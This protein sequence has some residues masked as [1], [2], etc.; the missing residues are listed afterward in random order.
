MKT[1]LNIDHC[2]CHYLLTEDSLFFKIKSNKTRDKLPLNGSLCSSIV[3]LTEWY[4]PW[5]LVTSGLRGQ[6]RGRVDSG[7]Q[8]ERAVCTFVCHRKRR[9]TG[10]NKVHVCACLLSFCPWGI[11]P[12]AQRQ[13]TTM[14]SHYLENIIKV[15]PF[16]KGTH[17]INS[18]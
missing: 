5:P 4:L 7:V 12:V 8:I 10:R 18:I 2:L 11:S 1:S 6:E 9:S 16:P 13:L 3:P 15:S 17:E 14:I